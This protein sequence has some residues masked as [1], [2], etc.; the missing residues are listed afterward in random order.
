MA[1]AVEDIIGNRITEGIIVVKYGYREDLQY[2]HQLEAGHPV[3]DDNGLK[4]SQKIIDV[5][6]KAGERD[7]IISCI[8]GGGSALLPYPV[9]PITLAQ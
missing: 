1:K 3:P 6:G 8:S 7:L 2:I 5:L 4:A 9:E